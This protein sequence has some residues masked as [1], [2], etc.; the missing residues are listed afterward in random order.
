[1]SEL[2]LLLGATAVLIVA[3]FRFALLLEP[4]LLFISRWLLLSGLLSSCG[5]GDEADEGEGFLVK[6]AARLLGDSNCPLFK[7]V[8]VPVDICQVHFAA[9]LVCFF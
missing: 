9:V 8:G 6:S 2:P 7:R 1:M 5:C 3:L 4:A